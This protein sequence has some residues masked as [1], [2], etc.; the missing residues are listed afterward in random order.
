MGG[1]GVA[2]R[3]SLFRIHYEVNPN[4]A[5]T[6]YFPIGCACLSILGVLRHEHVLLIIEAYNWAMLEGVETLFS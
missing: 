1:R 5:C 4:E 3:V 6:I 2:R